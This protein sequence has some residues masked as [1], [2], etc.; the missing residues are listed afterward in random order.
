MTTQ[1]A[2][3]RRNP[4]QSRAEFTLSA[5]REAGL[6]IL[7][8]KGAS[9]LT[10]NYIAEVAGVSIGAIYQYYPDKYAIV[11]DICNELLLAEL[12]EFDRIADQTMRCARESLEET[13]GFMVR[14]SLARH[15]KLY[16]FLKE[17]Y[18]EIHWR[19]D[20]EAYV[21]KK[22]PDRY[23]A[24]AMWL[25]LVLQ[26]HDAT[27]QVR[28]HARAAELVVDLINGTIHATLQRRPERIFDEHYGDDLVNLVLR[29]LKDSEA[30]RVH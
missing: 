3:R 7:E 1:P 11:A 17:Y 14:E 13:V 25:S 16:R 8:Q 27:L 19:Y 28:E 18:L 4:I 22:Y 9:R 24:T 5:I 23:M 20:F 10:T 26:Q 21:V 12:G 29:Y 2:I 30:L 15:R 6:K